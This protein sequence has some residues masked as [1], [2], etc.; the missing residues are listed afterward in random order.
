MTRKILGIDG[1]AMK[2]P[3]YDVFMRS[4]L[5]GFLL[6]RFRMPGVPAREFEEEPGGPSGGNEGNVGELRS[7]DSSLT[8][9]PAWLLRNRK[10]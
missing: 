3:T 10:T 2:K 5:L 6:R 4:P 8:L 9:L 1:I 7:S